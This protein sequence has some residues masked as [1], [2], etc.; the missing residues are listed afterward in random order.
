VT[1]LKDTDAVDKFD[2]SNFVPVGIAPAILQVVSVNMN[3]TFSTASVTFTDVTDLTASITPSSASNDVLVIVSVMLSNTVAAG[4]SQLQLTDGSNNVLAPNSAPGGRS[5]GFVSTNTV[6]NLNAQ[7]YTFNFLHSPATTSSFTYKVRARRINDTVVINR[8]GDATD[9][10]SR[11]AG[12]STITLM[13][14]AG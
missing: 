14:V 11:T 13:E 1:Y 6:T 7:I 8:S 9:A 2:G 4:G 3:D 5:E 12:S 10:A